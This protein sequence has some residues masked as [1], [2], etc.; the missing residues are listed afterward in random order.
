MLA[1]FPTGFLVNDTEP[2]ISS[3]DRFERVL[4]ADCNHIVCTL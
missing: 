2:K 1:V 3:L 4:S